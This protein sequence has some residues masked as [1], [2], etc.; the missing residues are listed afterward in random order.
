LAVAVCAGLENLFGWD[1]I[2]REKRM[3]ADHE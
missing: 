2:W 1:D 3:A